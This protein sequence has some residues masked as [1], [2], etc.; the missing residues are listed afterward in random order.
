VKLNV[1]D[2]LTALYG[3]DVYTHDNVIISGTH[4][5]ATPGGLGGTVLVD[6]TTFGFIKENHNAAVDGI[7]LSIQRAHENIQPA[8]MKMNIG[9]CDG[10]NINRSP[11]A[12]LLDPD[13]VNYVNNTDHE[14]TVLRIESTNGTELGMV[15]WFAVHGTSLNNTNML[16][17]GDNKGYA[18][19]LFE[20]AKNPPGTLPGTGA[21]VAAFGQSNLGDVSP[22]T[23]G[24]KCPDGSPC[25]FNT[26]TC[27]NPPRSQGCIAAGPGVDQY[28]SMRIIGLMQQEAA[29]A[30]YESA[31]EELTNEGVDYRYQYFDMQQIN[32]SA[33][34][35][36]TGQSG[37]TCQAAMGYAFAAGTTDG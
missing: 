21:F 24:A 17:S 37:Q 8:V 3:P 32:V 9:Q 34:F 28:D 19:Y 26:S 18:A 2:R 7:V 36:S 30:L 4:T 33:E 12:Y 14:M 35:T 1:I 27:G 23:M 6:L 15:S 29:M 25:D 5:H 20:K 16:V 10:C 22:N 31:T 11:S 13:A